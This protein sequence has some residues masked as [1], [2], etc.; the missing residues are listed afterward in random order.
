MRILFIVTFLFSLSACDKSAI[1]PTF[2]DLPIIEGYLEEG[3]PISIKISR[4]VALDES[5]VYSNDNMTALNPAL[6]EEDVLIPLT[7]AGE[8][9]YTSPQLVQAGKTYKLSF[10]YNQKL[11]TAQT[12][13]PVTPQ[14][15]TQSVTS[16]KAFSFSSGGSGMPTIPDPLKLTWDNTDNSYY[17]V[18]IENVETA[19]EAINTGNESPPARIF[20]NQPTQ[21]NS[22][23]IRVMQFNY[24]GKHHIKLYHLNPDY[25]ALYSTGSNTSQN[26]F[27]P[28]T[29]ITNGV[30]IFTGVAGKVLELAVTK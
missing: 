13:I 19:P 17:V 21:N 11:V 20:R 29:S 7:S 2:Q 6:Y 9:I 4:Q 22:Y 16:I 27:T 24:Y 5:A 1:A 25:A 14:N 10:T 26:L 12:V 23:E 8:G 18:L 30:G 28:T 15:Y 3:L